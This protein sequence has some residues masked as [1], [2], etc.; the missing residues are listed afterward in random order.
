MKN[1]KT[2]FQNVFPAAL[3]ACLLWA[4]GTAAATA[5]T[6]EETVAAAKEVVKKHQ[7][8]VVTVKLTLELTITMR[9]QERKQETTREAPGTVIDPSGLTVMPLSMVSPQGMMRGMRIKSNVIDAKLV[10]TDGKEIPGK[11]VMRDRDLDLAFFKPDAQKK[12]D[13]AEEAP[14]FPFLSMDKDVAPAPGLL[15]HVIVV[16]RMGR[17]L[18]RQTSVTLSSIAAI[19]KKPRTMYIASGTQ[20]GF[21]A[22]DASGKLTGIGVM[23]K[24]QTV[25][26]PVSEITD[27]AAQAKN[28]GG[29]A[30]ETDNDEAKEDKKEE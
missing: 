8:A 21:P 17:N 9:G 11:V 26:L 12:E 13:G 4:A 25:I 23:H 14:R 28:A 27:A 2:A 29:N 30:E 24:S 6:R 5:A 19:V 15:D 22:F 18:D 16:G 7:D 1:R 10:Q 3:A 20:L